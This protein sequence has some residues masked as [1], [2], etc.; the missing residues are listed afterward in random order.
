MMQYERSVQKKLRSLF[1]Y[2]DVDN[3]GKITEECLLNGLARLRNAQSNVASA[4]N[5]NNNSTNIPGLSISSTHV[6]NRHETNATHSAG[7]HLL[8]L[9]E[10]SIEELIRA[11]PCGDEQGGITLKAF[12]E[13]EAT[14]LPHLTNLKLLQ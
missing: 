3:D 9:P 6:A 7:E 10:Y 13:A 2:L 4:S 1:E 11:V 8:G 12:L 14:L 5:T